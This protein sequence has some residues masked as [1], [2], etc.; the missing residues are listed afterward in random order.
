[1]KKLLFIINALF[2]CLV[3]H[4]QIKELWGM[5]SSGGEFNIGVI[6]KTDD[7]GNNQTSQHSFVRKESFSGANPTRTSLV[8]ANNGKL[9]GIARTGGA[10]DLGVLFQY[11][12][13]NNIYAKKVDFAGAT[14]GSYPFGSLIMA[15]DGKLYGMTR[16]GGTSDLGVLFQ[17]DPSTNIYAKKLDFVGTNGASPF[18]SL[19]QAS[20]DKLYGMT[21][22]GGVNNGGVLF[23]YDPI[24][25]SLFKKLDF[26]GETNGSF[27]QGSLVQIGNGKIYGM[28]TYGGSNNKGVLFEYDLV[29]NKYSKKIDFDGV[30]NGGNPVGSLTLADNGKL[31]GVIKNGGSNNKGLL[32]E[33]NPNT[34]IY[35]KKLDF[36]GPA[37]GSSPDGS[38]LW[39]D[40]GK[41][42]GMTL[43]GGANDLGVLFQY[44]PSTDSFAKKVD[45]GGT[46]N[47]AYPDGSLV[48]ANDGKLY[49]MTLAGG[50]NNRG[51]L[52]Q[53]NAI[54][55][56]F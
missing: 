9:Y 31:Y 11:D 25:N 45:F 34:N 56:F 40:D 18:G 14:N 37:N 15:S 5:T 29:T 6:F 10:N 3:T 26:M 39:A 21:S 28:T 44:D 17:Y 22:S 35:S 4:A 52:F 20:D 36:D 30:T 32:F 49:G 41:L 1:M 46:A 53:Y 48:Q 42:Y 51:T 8:Q 47:G 38:L 2:F 27:P 19:M 13:D 55:N 33:Y 43:E 23:Q 24:A 50:E 54:A 16:A 7:Q 12:P